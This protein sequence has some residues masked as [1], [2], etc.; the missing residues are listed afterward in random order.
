MAR[1]TAPVCHAK[2][3][4]LPTLGPA[5]FPLAGLFFRPLMRWA[6]ALV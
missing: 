3:C 4:G 6:D 1:V 5:L 2:V